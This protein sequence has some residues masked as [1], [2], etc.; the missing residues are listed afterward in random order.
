MPAGV[1]S[2]RRTGATMHELRQK[3]GAQELRFA[4]DLGRRRSQ[5]AG[6]K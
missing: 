4:K 2:F 1:K 3:R 5:S 6:Q